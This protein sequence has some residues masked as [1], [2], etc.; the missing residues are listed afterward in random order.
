MRRLLVVALA[1]IVV[2]S[3]GA[4]T[5]TVAVTT[6]SPITAAGVTLSGVDQTK[7]F[8]VA[9]R[10][11]YDDTSGG[12]GNTF[13]WKVNVSATAPTVAGRSLPF[14]ILTGVTAGTCAV[15][16]SGNCTQPT[17]NVTWPI[18]INTT[19]A[20]IFNAAANT[21]QGTVI[22]TGTYTITYP[23]NAIAG[24]YSST[25]TYAVASGP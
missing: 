9:S 22:L 13:G 24:T 21:G 17:N 14:L 25:I 23:A 15:D 11:V 5:L 2:P 7:N 1:L 19:A 4:L 12:G 18:T 6:A 10:V 16:S 3:A 8:T 20:K